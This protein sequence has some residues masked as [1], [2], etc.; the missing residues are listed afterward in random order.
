MNGQKTNYNFE[1][2]VQGLCSDNK[3]KIKFFVRNKKTV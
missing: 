1:P 3:I 2:T